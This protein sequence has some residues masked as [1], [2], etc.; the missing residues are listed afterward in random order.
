MGGSDCCRIANAFSLDE[1]A[2]ATPTVLI[3]DMYKNDE[4]L[5]K[6]HLVGEYDLLLNYN[7]NYGI[8]EETRT[9]DF[10]ILS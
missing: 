8:Q 2:F 10:N 5:I 4:S 6:E 7:Q 3:P 9:N 1:S